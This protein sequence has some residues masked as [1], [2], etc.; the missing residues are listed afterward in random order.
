MKKKEKR[1]LECDV[2]LIKELK[3]KANIKG[4]NLYELTD[5]I[6][7]SYLLNN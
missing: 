7:K 1:F 5:R 6:I 3:E 4:L 2:K